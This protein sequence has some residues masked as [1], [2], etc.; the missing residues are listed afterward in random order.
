MTMPEFTAET[1]IYRT[2]NYYKMQQG[3][4]IR[5]G[6]SALM[7]M[8]VLGVT[9]QRQLQNVVRFR[10]AFCNCLC[11]RNPG[12]EPECICNCF[13]NRIIPL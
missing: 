3:A 6:V 8:Q 13:E 4:Q 9:A 2:S 12:E 1:S 11:W 5:Q 10:T 7:P